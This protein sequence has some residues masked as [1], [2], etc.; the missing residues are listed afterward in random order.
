MDNR[1]AKNRPSPRNE[2][3]Y[4]QAYKEMNPKANRHDNYDIAAVITKDG[5]KG[6]G[7][8]SENINRGHDKNY[9]IVKDFVPDNELKNNL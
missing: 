5:T 4:I 1:I 8:L 7:L 9:H 2:K 3:D 6:H